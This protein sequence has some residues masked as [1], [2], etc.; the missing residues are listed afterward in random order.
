MST[1]TVSLQSSKDTPSIS[2]RGTSGSRTVL[3]FLTRDLYVTR[4]ARPASNSLLLLGCA[5]GLAA[6][7]ETLT[8]HHYRAEGE[9][10]GIAFAQ[11]PPLDPAAAVLATQIDLYCRFGLA[12]YNSAICWVA[13]GAIC[14]VISEARWSQVALIARL[15]QRRCPLDRD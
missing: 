6:L 7:A 14:L 3:R 15:V 13:I 12:H 10:L 2:N 9:A 1:G 5:S 8:A 4:A 11:V